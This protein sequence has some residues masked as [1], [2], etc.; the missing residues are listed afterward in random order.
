MDMY[1]RDFRLS[2]TIIKKKLLRKSQKGKDI[3]EK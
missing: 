3:K 1:R 2:V